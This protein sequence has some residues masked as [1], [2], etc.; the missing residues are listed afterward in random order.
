MKIEDGNGDHHL[1]NTLTETKF[2]ATF[3][4]PSAW[5]PARELLSAEL[6]FF[7][8]SLWITYLAGHSL[9]GKTVFLIFSLF[10]AAV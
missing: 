3:C 4:L 9:A 7:F 5:I 8:C 6:P 1:Q 10:T 2:T